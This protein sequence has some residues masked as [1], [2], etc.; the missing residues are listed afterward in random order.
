MPSLRLPLVLLPGLLDDARLL[1]HQIGE[2]SDDSKN[3]SME[4]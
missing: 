4:E 1:R 3:L 2:V